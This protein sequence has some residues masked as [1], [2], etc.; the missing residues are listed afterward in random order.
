MKSP[1]LPAYLAAAFTKKLSRLSLKVPPSGALIIIALVHN[2]LRRHPSINCLVHRDNS[3]VINQDLT[4]P[5]EEHISSEGDAGVASDMDRDRQGIDL[6]NDEESDP[7]RS[8]AMRSSLW[9]IDTLRHHYCPPVSRFVLSLENDLTVRAKTTEVTISD[10]SSGSYSTIVGDELKRRC[11]QV[12]VAAYRTTP[13]CL[14]SES[15]FPGW[16]F[17]SDQVNDRLEC[18]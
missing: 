3:E 14:F 17:N 7:R 6:F 2:L 9:E 12:P 4:K 11:K 13:S 10:F 5:A 8:N 16:T 18:L 15:D 1:L